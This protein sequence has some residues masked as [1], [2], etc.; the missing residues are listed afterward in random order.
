MDFNEKDLMQIKEQ[1]L[2]LVEIQRQLEIFE[3]G[4]QYLNILDIATSGKGIEVLNT[5]NIERYLKKFEVFQGSLLKFVPASGAATRMFKD[6]YSAKKKLL[7]G[8]DLEKGEA[9]FF[10]SLS[11]FAFY[12]ELV[13]LPGYD[14]ENKVSI[15]DKIL[16]INGLAYS[17][18]PKGLV[19]FHKYKDENRSALEEQMLEGVSY[20][21]K[22]GLVRMHFT[23]NEQFY[24][25]FIE[26]SESY[27]EILFK[28]FNTEFDITFSYQK[29]Y[30]D[31]ISVDNLNHP[32]RDNEGKILFR[33]GGHGALLENL[34][35]LE[36][37]LIFI[38]N[39]DN[40]TKD[41]YLA[42]TSYFKKIL[43]GKLLDTKERIDYFLRK[44]EGERDRNLEGEIERFLSSELHINMPSV[45]DEIKKDFLIEKLNRPIRVCGVV[46]NEGEPGGGPFIIKDADGSTSLQILESAQINLDD[47]QSK[48]IFSM[49]THFNPVDIVCSVKDYKNRKFNL[50]K[51]SDPDT[52]FISHKTFNGKELK[53]LELPGLWNGAMSNWNTLFIEVPSTTFN[54]VKSVNDLLRDRHL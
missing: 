24:S 38:K 22:D 16:D 41:E 4:Q 36:S 9:L 7:N 47:P 15:I 23:I 17:I 20:A 53:A 30:T 28:K 44:L 11:K 31:T 1:G 18:L 33:P 46:K 50:M 51:Y 45:N 25:R 14:L 19:K 39:I 32:F 35:E 27:K 8:E 13:N 37:D 54:P 48:K 34:N 5:S 26:L 43:A 42:E 40:I 52:S 21:E 49:S 29:K 3:R 2:S 10:K 12:D 6:L